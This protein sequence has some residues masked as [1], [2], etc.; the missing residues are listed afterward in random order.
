M[1]R[2]IAI[3]LIAIGGA[4]A[5]PALVTTV[6][7]ATGSAIGMM[8]EAA[9]P[10]QRVEAERKRLAQM[11]KRR[12][13]KARR[14]ARRRAR[15]AGLGDRQPGDW[16]DRQGFDAEQIE[17]INLASEEADARMGEIQ[18]RERLLKKMRKDKSYSQEDIDAE[19]EIL[20]MLDAE[21]ATLSDEFV[22]A[23][24]VQ[25][26]N[27][28][29]RGARFEGVDPGIGLVAQPCNEASCG[30]YTVANVCCDQTGQQFDP[31]AL[32]KAARDRGEL[33]DEGMTTLDVKSFAEDELNLA[34]SAVKFDMTK[35]VE[36]QRAMKTMEK[37]A[38]I[39]VS[40]IV[41]IR[42]SPVMSRAAR[43]RFEGN[44]QSDAVEYSHF[45]AVQ[46]KRVP[47]FEGLR[48]VVNDP[49]GYVYHVDPKTF[50][51]HSTGEFVALATKK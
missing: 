2:V 41:R 24:G 4:V 48:V 9:T 19:L 49:E 17:D 14:A 31:R 36:R 33:T 5:A 16:R 7:P 11:R 44:Q 32:V 21:L 23:Y 12:Q 50:Q 39:G 30:V 3:A 38:E 29:L 18:A 37:A 27:R 8:A 1:T 43:Q 40:M 28:M 45:V 10:Q 47:G 35:P 26:F 15:E 22:K 42:N 51:Q 34:A 13:A 6:A 25:L 46:M 20:D